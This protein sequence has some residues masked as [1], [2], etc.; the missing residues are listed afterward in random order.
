MWDQLHF[1]SRDALTLVDGFK[2]LLEFASQ[3]GDPKIF[4][5]LRKPIMDRAEAFRKTLVDAE[6]RHVDALV[7][8]AG[9][10]YRRPLTAGEVK[11]IRGLYA[12]LRSQEIPHDDAVRLTLAR[13]LVS[14]AFLYRAE[15]PVAGTA[16]GP[17]SDL[18]L[19]TRLSYFLWSSAP[20][21]ELRRAAEAGELRD[22]QKLSAQMRRMVADARTRRLA[23]EFACHWVHINDFDHLDEK[24][25]QHFPTF[26]ALRGA[27]FEESIRFF[28]DLFQSDRSVL[29]VLDAD[30]TFLNEP[31]AKHY[32]IP[33]VTGPEWRRVEGVK[34]YSRGGILAQSTTLAKQSGASRTSP[35]LRG[36]WISEVLLG[37]RLPRPPKG[38]PVLPDDESATAGLTVRQ[39]VEKHTSDPKCAVCH[40]RIDPFGFSLE[41]FDAIGRLRDKDLADRTIDTHAKTLDGSEFEGIEGLRHYLLTVRR[42]AFVGQFCRKLLGYALGRGVQLSDEPLLAQMQAE[43]KAKDYRVIVAVEAIVRSRQFREIRG[44][45]TAYED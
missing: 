5:P 9:Q 39:L 33:G 27:M 31:L 6:P 20:D 4:E 44:R 7:A 28:T 25:E 23:V 38:V 43:L 26:L 11:D 32:G 22:P 18:E 1:I 13:L 41:A 19:A 35:I 29:D 42:E 3:D 40:Q 37:E 2:Q 24:S 16:Q 30:Y 34:K 21:A 17:V 45:E 10:A 8:F 12:K 36:N 15:K 14:P